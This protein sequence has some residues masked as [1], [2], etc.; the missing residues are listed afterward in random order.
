MKTFY[1]L[2]RPNLAIPASTSWYLGDLGEFR[3]KRTI[4]TR[5]SPLIESAV[6][7]GLR[8]VAGH[9]C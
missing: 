5:Q 3:G 6:S 1:L 2:H 4:Y 8:L 7:S 9:E